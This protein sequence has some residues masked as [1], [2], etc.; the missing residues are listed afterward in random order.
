MH[1]RWMCELLQGGS[2]LLYRP[3]TSALHR[4]PDGTSRN[5]VNGDA[6]VLARA[7]EWDRFRAVIRGTSEDREMDDPEPELPVQE[8]E[9]YDFDEELCDNFKTTV[10]PLRELPVFWTGH[11]EL[12]K[13]DGQ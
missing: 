5:P 1:F 7:S 12:E 11:T 3:G 10:Q 2:R 13:A 6:L 4:G 8:M 9:P